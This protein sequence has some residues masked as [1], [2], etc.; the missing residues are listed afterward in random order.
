MTLNLDFT[1]GLFLNTFFTFLPT[2]LVGIFD[3][4]LPAEICL[5]FP[6]LY[7]QGIQQ[8]LFTSQRFF[9]YLGWAGYHSLICF[10]AT[11]YILYEQSFTSSGLSTDSQ[12]I[13]NTLAFTAITVINVFS[14]ISWFNWTWITQVS[15]WGSMIFWVIY[16]VVYASDPNSPTYG[17]IQVYFQ[18]PMFYAA[19]AILVGLC[20][21]P[22]MAIRAAQI[23]A[24]P[25]DTQIGREIYKRQVKERQSVASDNNTVQPTQPTDSP[26]HA[27]LVFRGRKPISGAESSPAFPVDGFVSPMVVE[28]P[29]EVHD[30]D[31]NRK[32][33]ITVSLRSGVE[34]ATKFFKK[35]PAP[36]VEEKHRIFR[37]G[38]IVY[39]GAD[40]TPVANTGFAFSHAEGMLDII[41]PQI[42]NLDVIEEDEPKMDT[43]KKK[44]KI[45]R[46]RNLSKSIQTVF[47][48][49][50]GRS[51]SSLAST[52]KIGSIEDHADHS[53]AS[54]SR[55]DEAERDS[56]GV[57]SMH[58][59]P[60]PRKPFV[61][62]P[63]SLLA[64]EK[65]HRK[66]SA[67]APSPDGHLK[68]PKQRRP[69]STVG[70]G[71]IAMQSQHG[72]S[73]IR[74]QLVITPSDRSFSAPRLLATENSMEEA[75][76]QMMSS[77]MSPAEHPSDRGSTNSYLL[78]STDGRESN[79]S[80]A[81]H[82]DQEQSE[83]NNTPPSTQSNK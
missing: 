59:A 49:K 10:F 20:L 40:G 61:L 19:I 14:A 44:S 45:T 33:S 70:M 16:A 79:V 8:T 18:T 32:P 51:K 62:R 25:T 5:Q 76:Q 73:Q 66:N 9:E 28:S 6:D 83:P 1:Y 68:V 42:R 54:K 64:D 57:R 56:V 36:A 11:M 22:N 67:R 26:D 12:V 48:M 31:R 52:D 2:I 72:Q 13:G 80:R 82:S 3:Q 21:L 24:N 39:M 37:A 53:R 55:S 81:P 41:T 34:K 58:G 17:L 74:N 78:S 47:S 7:K 50:K 23:Y 29:D 75:V 43:R 38:S 71:P 46:F 35:T 65:I 27:S 4:D 77:P 30:K 60:H 15:L 63:T 69:S